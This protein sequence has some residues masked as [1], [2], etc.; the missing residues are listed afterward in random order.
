MGRHPQFTE[1]EL[2]EFAQ[3][4]VRLL[5]KHKHWQ[6][7]SNQKCAHWPHW[8]ELEREFEF[9]PQQRPAIRRYAEMMD[10]P[11]M[12]DAGGIRIAKSDN[13]RALAIKRRISDNG[14][15]AKNLGKE[16]EAKGEDGV[17]RLAV[18]LDE[19]GELG[20]LTTTLPNLLDAFPQTAAL[21][22]E[23]RKLL[24]PPSRT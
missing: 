2:K 14:T 8:P 13:I 21:A 20:L 18:G 4:I 7:A 22:E 10:A 16:V 5:N 24:P 1:D 9:T 12:I 15:R 11:L 17:R 3:R 6:I 23:I 19:L